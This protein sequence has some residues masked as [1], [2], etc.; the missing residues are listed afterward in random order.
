M[1][2]SLNMN[3]SS[4]IINNLIH[5][6]NSNY[7]EYNDKSIKSCYNIMFENNLQYSI[8][9]LYYYIGKNPGMVINSYDNTTEVLIPNIWYNI[10]FDSFTNSIKVVNLFQ[11]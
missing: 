11:N 1:N 9:I 10:S 3:N 4:N 2:N 8:K 5:I 6:N 7:L